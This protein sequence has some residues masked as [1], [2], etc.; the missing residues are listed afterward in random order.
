[1]QLFATSNLWTPVSHARSMS[2]ILALKIARAVVHGRAICQ[3]FEGEGG[4]L[5][6]RSEPPKDIGK[7]DETLVLMQYPHRWKTLEK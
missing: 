6:R 2:M 7:V 3:S 1:M 4:D 5:E